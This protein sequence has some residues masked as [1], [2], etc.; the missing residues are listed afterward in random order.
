MCE[1][2]MEAAMESYDNN[3]GDVPYKQRYKVA[4]ALLYMIEKYKNG[5]ARLMQRYPRGSYVKILF[6]APAY[7]IFMEKYEEKKSLLENSKYGNKIQ[8][9]L[10]LFEYN[11]I[12]SNIS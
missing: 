9:D 4:A 2:R 12:C 3:N 10:V 5:T 1:S 11:F 8:Q 7:K 6:G